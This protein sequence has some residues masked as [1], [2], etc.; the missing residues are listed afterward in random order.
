MTFT[1]GTASA[2]R[3]SE[4]TPDIPR[5]KLIV[6][7]DNRK[8]KKG[9][10]VNVQAV[11]EN[12]GEA[13]QPLQ[14]NWT[15]DHAGSGA[16]VTF[17][18]N[19]PGKQK[20][21]V[22]VPTV[23]GASVEFEVGDLTA[24][25]KLVSPAAAKVKVGAPV[26]FSA[27]L[28]SDGTAVSGNYIYRFQPSPEVKFDTNE[29]AGKK[30]NA[31]FSKPGREKV[32]VQVLER[33]GEILETV[34]ESEQIE[35]EVGFP[36]LRIFFDQAQP[37]IGKP[38]KARVEVDPAELKN[39]DF[40]W[41]L[42]ANAKQTLQSP[43]VREVTFIPQN[44]NPITVKVKARVPFSGEDLGAKEATLRAQQYNVTV[45][46]LGAE[47]PKPQVWREGV[48][49]VTVENAIAVQQFVGLRAEVSPLPENARFEWILNDDSHFAGNNVTQ[50]IRVSRSQIGSCEATVIVRDKDGLELGRGSGT[51]NVSISQN[52][53]EKAKTAG[54]AADKLNQA[55]NIA[56]EGRLDEAITIVDGVLKA[57]PTN[58]EAATLSQRL[59][60]ERETI[61]AQLA[62]VRTLIDQQRFAEASN[63][64]MVAKSLQNLYPPVLEIEKELNEKRSKH[65]LEKG[66]QLKQTIKKGDEYYE[67]RKYAEAFKEYDKALQIDSLNV[68]AFF[69]RGVTKLA[70][71]DFAG[72][73]EDFNR[74]LQIDP[75]NVGAFRFRGITK[76]ELKDFAGAI[77]DFNRA[78]Q[79]DPSNVET[80]RSR[81]NTKFAMKDYAGAISDDT[82]IIELKPNDWRA[83]SSRAIAKT[84]IDDNQGAIADFERSL[85]LNPDNEDARKALA[86]LK[87][88]MAGTVPQKE[89]S[90][91]SGYWKYSG[92]QIRWAEPWLAESV[93]NPKDLP[94]NKV[95]WN[96]EGIVST[97]YSGAEFDVTRRDECK[98]WPEPVQ[99]RRFTWSRMPDIIIPGQAYDIWVSSSGN[100]DGALDVSRLT[101]TDQSISWLAT[102]VRSKVD[103]QIKA[104]VPQNSQNPE[105]MMILV[106][107]GSGAAG[108]NTPNYAQYVYLYKWVNGPSDSKINAEDTQDLL[109]LGKE[110]RDK[111]NYAE[112]L[113]APPKPPPAGRHSA[114]ACP[115][116]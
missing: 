41:E 52:E 99:T 49:L 102:A 108:R 90:S 51:F 93:A 68:E 50:Q 35:I 95:F 87:E 116:E 38:V 47:G 59:K 84:W 34:A 6:S 72:A 113:G 18:A 89:P 8:L 48:G 114:R 56:K 98:F 66:A 82:K 62:K 7:P 36:E 77:E 100:G 24:E 92:E 9:D 65:E 2:T 91:V 73:I 97:S 74:A 79:I 57:N 12:A 28:M 45:K 54:G 40:R 60:K 37:L 106:H 86:S 80:I 78:L 4:P 39:I 19:K 55:K 112:A 10:V 76:R 32:W 94:W 64:L 83:W 58:T 15:G 53:L 103:L 31:V 85:A 105:T 96:S 16:N 75:L 43:D 109:R 111:G 17:L 104:D 67:A 14:F 115:G 25:L 5:L 88:K 71:K 69:S 29:S 11:I 33:K 81:G 30:T 26:T 27:N 13:K 23:G 101:R 22:D 21:S 1:A 63:E 20:L 44:A 46:V 110:Q 42:P 107:L 3:E 70:M 61:T